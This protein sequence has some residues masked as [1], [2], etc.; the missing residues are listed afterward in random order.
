MESISAVGYLPLT[1]VNLLVELSLVEIQVANRSKRLVGLPGTPPTE[2]D[3]PTGRAF[4]H[5][6]STPHSCRSVRGSHSTRRQRTS[7]KSNMGRR[8]RTYVSD[9]SDDSSSVSETTDDETGEIPRNLDGTIWK[10]PLRGWNNTPRGKARQALGTQITMQIPPKTDCWR[11]TRNN[12]NR[13]NAPYHWHKATADFEVTCKIG[14]NMSTMYD[15]AGIMVRLDESNW[16]LSGMEFFNNQMNHSTSVTKGHTDW[17]LTPLPKNAQKVGIWFKVRRVGESVEC[18]YSFDS[19]KWVMT[20]ECSFSAR[21]VLYVGI[22]GGSPI[23]D[24]FRGSWEYYRCRN[25]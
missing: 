21:P 18:S 25:L 10:N 3:S 7:K 4:I 22:C 15:K 1:G 16:I 11:K 12:F 2:P 9:S 5:M 24:G 6:Y 8:S 13:D 20:R 17:S 19:E 23:G 14:G